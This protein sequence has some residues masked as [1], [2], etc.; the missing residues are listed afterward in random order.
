MIKKLKKFKPIFLYISKN[1][2]FFLYIFK[3]NCFYLCI[4]S[5]SWDDYTNFLTENGDCNIAIILGFDNGLL[6]A[7]SNNKGL[8]T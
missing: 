2:F 5:M 7:S 6:W 4:I 1:F 3:F 8:E